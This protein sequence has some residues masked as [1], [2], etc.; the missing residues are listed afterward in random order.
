MP[1]KAA[2]SSPC[3]TSVVAVGPPSVA[4]GMTRLF[5][6]LAAVDS[7]LS[8][9][10]DLI[11]CK[12]IQDPSAP[13]MSVD[14]AI[15]CDARVA[16]HEDRLRTAVNYV[17]ALPV[18]TA[19]LRNCLSLADV[20]TLIRSTANAVE[21]FIDVNG[22]SANVEEAYRCRGGCHLRSLHASPFITVRVP[23]GYAKEFDHPTTLHLHISGT[24]NEYADRER[25]E[26]GFIASVKTFCSQVQCHTIER[27]AYLVAAFVFENC[28]NVSECAITVEKSSIGRLTMTDMEHAGI[29]VWCLRSDP[30]M[31]PFMAALQSPR[32][33]F[34]D[35]AR[36]VTWE[37]AERPEAA[38]YDC[39]R[40]SSDE[41]L[42]LAFSRFR[43]ASPE[44]DFLQQCLPNIL[45]GAEAG[46][47]TRHSGT[48]A[49][50]EPPP[51]A[52]ATRGHSRTGG[53]RV[54]DVGAGDGFLADMIAREPR[55]TALHYVAIEP[56]ACFHGPLRSV[57]PAAASRDA[58]SIIFG[59]KFSVDSRPSHFPIHDDVD[60]GSCSYN[61]GPNPGRLSALYH[62][63]VFCHSLYAIADPA[64]AVLTALTH[65]LTDNHDSNDDHRHHPLGVRGEVKTT[66]EDGRGDDESNEVT[67]AYNVSSSSSCVNQHAFS[68]SSPA[69]V[70]VLRSDRMPQLIGD[71]CRRGGA[72][73]RVGHVC[74]SERWQ[75]PVSHDLL[76]VLTGRAVDTEEAAAAARAWLGLGDDDCFTMQN[77]VA[78]FTRRDS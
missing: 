9:S 47:K 53:V 33:L 27:V 6:G 55:E 74:C 10:R 67:V 61:G 25:E 39:L 12:A 8:M 35:V 65:F 60:G 56:N 44:Y 54:L 1:L 46:P 40:T 17:V 42:A 32:A 75:V 59:T 34:R 30:M 45:V 15:A 50:K 68:T 28:S 64:G 71:V 4:C 70:V 21:I 76:E 57:I 63:V 13:G 19:F 77:T 41:R 51:P 11:V 24:E 78:V 22:T 73:V 62:R 23:I 49:A 43:L 72:S 3:R 31:L 7:S 69:V 37:A 52:C 58:T 2:S 48:A 16:A 38:C 66:I 5:K 36:G 18:I 20:A 26:R 29:R 14:L